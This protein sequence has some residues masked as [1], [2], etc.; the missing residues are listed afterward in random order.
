MKEKLEKIL[1]LA[2]TEI[3][4][5]PDVSNL[6]QLRIKYLGKKGIVTQFL[7]ELGK[8]PPEVRPHQG[9]LV[10]RIKKAIE[11]TLQNRKAEINTAEKKEQLDKEQVDVTLPGRRFLLGKKHPITKTLDKIQGIF[12]QMG[13]EIAQGPEIE[14]DYYNFEALNIPRDHPARDM[15]ATFFITDDV[16]LR[17]HISP[18]QIR[19]MEK[20]SP[21]IRIIVP[22]R[23]YRCDD[24]VSHSPMFHQVEVL[25]VDVGV[26]FAHLKGVL[27]LFAREMFGPQTE[28]RFRPS[29]FPF[30][31]PSAEVDVSCIICQGKGCRICKHS[32]WLEILGAGMVH[33]AVFGFVNYDAEKYTGFAFGMGVE[34][35]AMLKYGIDDIRL[36]FENDIRFLEQF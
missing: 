27:S 26:T 12:K 32:G 16:V 2:Q 4:N 30:T 1:M 33:P 24:D 7:Q 5:C 17:T 21:P 11:V 31:E 14:L 19:V 22:G 28:T 25:V 10:N 15:Q 20:K 8:L 23:V 9:Q 6:E 35:I 36:F 29:Y 18:V 13:F 3:K 34:R